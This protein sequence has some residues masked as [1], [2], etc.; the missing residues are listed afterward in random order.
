MSATSDALPVSLR[1]PSGSRS[2]RR[3]RREGHV[4][5]V[6]C[7]GDD[8]PQAVQVGQLTLNRFLA[9]AGSVIEIAIDGASTPGLIRET[10]RHPAPAQPQHVDFLRVKMD[11][12]IQ[13]TVPLELTGVDEAPGVVEGGIL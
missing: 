11:E 10:V 13:T 9:H 8:E 2:A 12:P 5:G 4:P 6:V 1:D 3:P 7:G